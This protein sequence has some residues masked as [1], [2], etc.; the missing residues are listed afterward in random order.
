MQSNVVVKKNNTEPLNTLLE[1]CNLKVEF[2]IKVKEGFFSKKKILH[3][4]NGVSFA[5]SASETLGI[6]GESGCGKSTLVRALLR[7]LP[8]EEAISG[9]VLWCNN[10]VMSF[11]RK[12]LQTMRKDIEIVF[13]DPL[14]SLNPRMNIL[15][16]ISEP[17]VIHYPKLSKQ[18]IITKVSEAMKM[19][20][21]N[22]ATMYRYPHEFSGGQSQRIGIA[23]AIILKPKLIVCDEAV[24]ALDVSI[25]AQII[26]LLQQL[27]QELKIAFLFISHD[28]GVV[29]YISDR[30]M[31]LYLGEIME[32]SK[33]E[34]LY[35]NPLHPYTK[36]LIAAV[37]VPDPELES[38]KERV[39][40]PGDIPSP[41]EKQKG[42]PF[43]SRCSLVFDKCYKEKPKLLP[44]QNSLVA[45]HKVK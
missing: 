30:V 33:A 26:N 14:A 22:P 7:L 4:V 41:F 6:V 11:S 29:E 40:I 8:E 31:V 5:L 34:D 24:S 13:Q 42:C 23:R 27:K 43:A 28:L 18:E 20:G 39:E 37:P 9:K 38:T 17:L 32:L 15:E 12:Q 35:K 21:L 25:K 10:N 2:N 1:V 44:V 45:C 16:I 3:A 36:A 19:V